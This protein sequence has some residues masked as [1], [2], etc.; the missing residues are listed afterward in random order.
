MNSFKSLISSSFLAEISLKYTGQGASISKV[1]FYQMIE[2]ETEQYLSLNTQ[3]DGLSF[4]NFLNA[5]TWFLDLISISHIIQRTPK[6]IQFSFKASNDVM[7]TLATF[8]ILFVDQND[9]RSRIV[10]ERLIDKEIIEVLAALLDHRLCF[11]DHKDTTNT[12]RHQRK[13]IARD[14]CKQREITNTTSLRGVQ[15]HRWD[16]WFLWCCHC[17]WT[18][19]SWF[20]FS[21]YLSLYEGTCRRPSIHGGWSTRTHTL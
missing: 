8:T 3:F 6:D 13:H 1:N 14:G 12:T 10:D 19:T 21:P 7:V 18:L 5:T 9:K 17:S 4:T 11:I 16:G 20:R 2:T 15:G